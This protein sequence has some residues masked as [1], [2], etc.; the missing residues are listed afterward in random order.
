M[1]T[2]LVRLHDNFIQWNKWGKKT[3][4]GVC[5]YGCV[6]LFFI[7]CSLGRSV[8]F[9]F[10]VY[11]G[12]PS[13]FL[14][15]SLLLVEFFVVSFFSFAWHFISFA[16]MFIQ[17][18]S[19]RELL[20]SFTYFVWVWGFGFIMLNPQRALSLYLSN[21]P[22]CTELNWTELN[23]LV[24]VRNV[25]VARRLIH[26]DM[27]SCCCCRRIQLKLN[28]RMSERPVFVCTLYIQTREGPQRQAHTRIYWL[29][30]KTEKNI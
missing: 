30:M 14:P 21:S 11:A 13:T 23:E 2:R 3:I 15:L 22:Y 26:Y 24:F 25:S 27:C 4:H 18:N 5:V 12:W 10:A 8:R 9:G 29:D 16:P 19:V 28:A 17:R 20:F 6:D 1:S 7:V